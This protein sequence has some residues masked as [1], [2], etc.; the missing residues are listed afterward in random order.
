MKVM[1]EVITGLET[2]AL[3]RLPGGNPTPAQGLR[4]LLPN[5][6]LDQGLCQ[7]LYSAALERQV[8]FVDGWGEGA[9][10]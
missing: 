10:I 4:Y 8:E 1:L 6:S 5:K 9:N 7:S 3:K 2:A